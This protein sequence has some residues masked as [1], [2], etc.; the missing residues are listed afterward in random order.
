MKILTAKEKQAKAFEH[1]KA[2]MG[3]KNPMQ[4]PKFTKVAVNVGIGSLKDKKKMDVIIDR[5]NKI[6]G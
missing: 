1:L 2:T 6:T 4:A 5:L 3:Y